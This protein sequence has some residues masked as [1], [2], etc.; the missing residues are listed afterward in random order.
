M[1]TNDDILK[2]CKEL[3]Y[4]LISPEVV[5]VELFKVILQNINLRVKLAGIREY[6]RV[7][8]RYL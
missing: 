6:N 2:R 5:K 1:L 4:D 8:N 3:L 7:N